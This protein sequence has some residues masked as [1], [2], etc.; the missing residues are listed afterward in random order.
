[1]GNVSIWMLMRKRIKIFRGIL[2]LN[3]L[4]S[5][6]NIFFRARAKCVGIKTPSLEQKE[7]LFLG[8]TSK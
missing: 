5:V 2:A 3:K 7:R 8:F 4:N 1:M 6:T